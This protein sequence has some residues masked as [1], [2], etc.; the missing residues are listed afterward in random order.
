MTDM[1]SEHVRNEKKDISS[2]PLSSMCFVVL[3]ALA[4]QQREHKDIGRFL[5]LAE[6]SVPVVV[7][8]CVRACCR[9]CLTDE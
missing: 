6:A 9:C 8:F 2:S 7:Y 1:W 3:F 5:P 4:G